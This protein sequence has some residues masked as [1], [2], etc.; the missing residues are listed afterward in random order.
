MTIKEFMEINPILVTSLGGTF[1]AVC[2]ALGVR[3]ILKAAYERYCK[4]ADEKDSDHK[5]I[6]E[7]KMLV[8]Q[9]LE[10]LDDIA[11]KDEQ[12]MDNDMLLLEDR[13]LFMQRK[14]IQVGKVSKSCM[15]RYHL[16][17]KRYLA[18]NEESKLDINDE[19]ELNNK[20]IEKMFEEGK[21]VENFWDY[22]ERE[23]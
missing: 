3:E 6:E 8:N 5:D 2:G 15:P 4:K 18:L 19:I 17:Y 11:S 9:I 12:F 13:I 7:L 23:A 10:R 14:A 20:M 22:Y 21:V 1:V 16:L